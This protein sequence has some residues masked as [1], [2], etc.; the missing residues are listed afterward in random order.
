M[1]DTVSHILGTRDISYQTLDRSAGLIS[2]SIELLNTEPNYD[3]KSPATIGYGARVTIRSNIVNWTHDF[4]A[5]DKL[6]AVFR[7]M[8]LSDIY[9][10]QVC[11]ENKIEIFSLKPG[12]IRQDFDV[13]RA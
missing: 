5:E 4:Y 9:L 12:D 6:Q 13:Y 8:W 1:S 10:Q 11:R 7:C 2:L 3:D